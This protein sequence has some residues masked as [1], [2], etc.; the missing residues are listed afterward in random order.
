MTNT[1]TT[2]K[3]SHYSRALMALLGMLAAVLLANGA[4]RA[5]VLPYAN[6]TPIQIVDKAPADPYP[7][8]I[9][10]QN[11]PG[12]ITDVDVTL[13]GYTHSYPDDV[14]VLLV[15]PDGNKVLLMSDVGG[16]SV[17]N[18][19]NLTFSDEAT[20]SLPDFSQIL[21]GTYKPTRGATSSGMVPASFP[22]APAGPYG[23]KLSVFDGIS[24]NG[25]W[26]LYVLDDDGANAGKFAGGWQLTITNDL[27]ST[28]TTHPRVTTVGPQPGATGVSPTASVNANF[29]ESVQSTTIN[30]NTFKLFRKGSTTKV[31]A[32]VSPIGTQTSG[33][34]TGAL[35]DPT[36]S[37]K[38]GATYK[39]VVTT[40][41]KDRVG[42]PLDQ[43]S[44]KVGNQQKAWY[45]TVKP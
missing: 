44:T 31:E 42:N 9:N 7:S 1:K 26:D 8:R 36:N 24:P 30:T 5:A 12:K 37:L 43:N 35:L 22:S 16:N 10:V 14:D 34:A 19:V 45:F 29:S 25:A 15:G 2:T 11:A 33:L 38:S 40:G 3:T 27:D 6:F 20:K 28:D 21:S 32:T 13:K 23:T 4:A 18:G 41:V 17:L 39:A